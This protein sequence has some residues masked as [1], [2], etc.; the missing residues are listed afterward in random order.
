[1]RGGGGGGTRG[2][3]PPPPAKQGTGGEPLGAQ[4]SPLV[5]AWERTTY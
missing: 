4:D 1:V 3:P 2:R 5:P